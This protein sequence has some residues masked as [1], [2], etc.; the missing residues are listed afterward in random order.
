MV[1]PIMKDVFFL[2]QKS[3]PATKA[4]LQVGKDLQDMIKG[5]IIRHIHKTF[6]NAVYMNVLFENIPEIDTVYSGRIINVQLHSRHGCNIFNTCRNLMDATPV[7]H[8]QL[9][10][11]RSNSQADRRL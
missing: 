4:D 11:S 7:L 1:K 2:G 3:E 6:I 10:H 8:P 5:Q 9:L